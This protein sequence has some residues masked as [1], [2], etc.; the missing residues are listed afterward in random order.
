MKPHVSALL[1]LT[2]G[3]IFLAIAAMAYSA[4]QSLIDNPE[5]F[6]D[7]GTGL[8]YQTCA[9]IIGITLGGIPILAALGF[10]KVALGY[11]PKSR[12]IQTN[13]ATDDKSTPMIKSWANITKMVNCEYCGSVIPQ[14][15][16]CCP[17]C[18]APRKE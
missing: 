13:R 8:A 3:I 4:G 15:A 17:H 6:R 9:V 18:G 11:G 12:T 7:I 14:T 2:I 10:T 16:T 5:T 1:S